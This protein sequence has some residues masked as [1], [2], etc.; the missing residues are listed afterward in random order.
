MTRC[1]T[2]RERK[3]RQGPLKAPSF[4][5][6]VSMSDVSLVVTV[7]NSGPRGTG[8]FGGLRSV[9]TVRCTR[10]GHPSTGAIPVRQRRSKTAGGSRTKLRSAFGKVKN[11]A[12]SCSD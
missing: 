9:V 8:R 5:C 12:N 3:T 4:P 7:V 11:F 2:E 6:R 10:E 1:V